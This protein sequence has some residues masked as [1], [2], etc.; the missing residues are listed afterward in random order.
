M[1]TRS[2]ITLQTSKVF[3][4]FSLGFMVLRS[5]DR[6]A[7]ADKK[8]KAAVSSLLQ[9]QLEKWMESVLRLP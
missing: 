5:L 7:D 9:E 4:S 3:I 2:D 1:K 6:L 8:Q